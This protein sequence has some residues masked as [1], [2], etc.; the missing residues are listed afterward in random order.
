MVLQLAVDDQRPKV[1]CLGKNRERTR[2][3]I[4]SKKMLRKGKA[5]RDEDSGNCAMPTSG[6]HKQ[7]KDSHESKQAQH[8]DGSSK[9]TEQMKTEWKERRRR[10]GGGGRG[11]SERPTILGICCRQCC[12]KGTKAKQIIVETNHFTAIWQ[13]Q[14]PSIP[15]P[16]PS[17]SRH[18]GFLIDEIIYYIFK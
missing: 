3:K 17:P 16:P 12:C 5:S 8:S 7:W 9:H 6:Y 1:K 14:P 4:V 2:V 10:G 15:P 13:Q 11:G 18:F